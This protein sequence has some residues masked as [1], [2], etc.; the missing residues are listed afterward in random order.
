MDKYRGFDKK[1]NAQSSGIK[2]LLDMKG[3]QSLLLDKSDLETSEFSE[4]DDNSDEYF[5]EM[6]ETEIEKN[7]SDMDQLAQEIIRTRQ[8]LRLGRLKQRVRTR[9]DYLNFFKVRE[10]AGSAFPPEP[11]EKDLN[12]IK[13]FKIDSEKGRQGY[14]DI[15]KRLEEQET[16][17]QERKTE[18]THKRE[19]ATDS[20]ELFEKIRQMN[21]K[22]DDWLQDID[23]CI[24]MGE[25]INRDIGDQLG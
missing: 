1:A 18:S 3:S 24:K 22:C 25:D 5:V 6:S 17:M 2:L 9:E 20:A 23:E 10:D 11:V 12:Y 7:L 16:S 19:E 4:G 21:L 8:K 13:K 14:A 15:K